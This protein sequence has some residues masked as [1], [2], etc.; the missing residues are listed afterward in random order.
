MIY[1]LRLPRALVLV[2]LTLWL[3]GIGIV[4]LLINVFYAALTSTTWRDALDRVDAHRDRT[5]RR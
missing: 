1:L 4:A 3:A 5:A 2:G